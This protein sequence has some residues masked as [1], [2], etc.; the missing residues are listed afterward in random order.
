MHLF[1][2]WHS[3]DVPDDVRPLIGSFEHHN[4]EFVHSVFNAR[5]AMRFIEAHFSGREAEAFR[6]CAV[7]SMQADYFRYCALLACGGISVDVDTRCLRPLKGLVDGPSEAELYVRPTGQVIAGFAIFKAPRHP[8]LSAVLAMATAGIEA[9]IEEDAWTVTGPALFTFL[10]DLHA[11]GS[12]DDQAVLDAWTS[13][14]SFVKPCSLWLEALRTGPDL[15]TLFR[16]VRVSPLAKLANRIES[17][18]QLAYK[19][20]TDHWLNVRGSLFAP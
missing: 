10:Y 2:Y 16:G 4:R 1:Q 7:P 3:E 11:A 18:P 20:S 13:Q 5:S 12:V 8:L 19:S 17:T 14:T 15:L 9:R 6:V